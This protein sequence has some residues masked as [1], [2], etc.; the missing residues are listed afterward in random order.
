MYLGE[1]HSGDDGQHD[2]LPLGGVGVLLVLQQPGLQGAGGLPGGV[3]TARRSIAAGI[4]G[5]RPSTTTS[6]Q[7]VR[8]W[9]RHDS[10]SSWAEME[11]FELRELPVS[12]I[13]V[14]SE[15]VLIRV[16]GWDLR[17]SR[18]CRHGPFF[19]VEWALHNKKYEI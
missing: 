1:G 5:D 18:L 13:R 3:L 4:P 12:I 15:A 10:R 17:R 19:G 16:V 8:S 2:L 7:G 14:L 6:E 11:M 9:G